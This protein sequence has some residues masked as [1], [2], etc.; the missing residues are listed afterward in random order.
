MRLEASMI[1]YE[2]ALTCCVNF[3]GIQDTVQACQ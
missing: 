3:T 2:H 1:L